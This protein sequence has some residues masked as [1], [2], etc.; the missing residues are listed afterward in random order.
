MKLKDLAEATLDFLLVVHEVDTNKHEG[1]ELSLIRGI[2]LE[3]YIGI[4]IEEAELF[5]IFLIQFAGTFL[6]MQMA[7]VFDEFVLELSNNGIMQ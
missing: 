7:E 5:L 1:R 6:A 2:I 3:Y 4:L